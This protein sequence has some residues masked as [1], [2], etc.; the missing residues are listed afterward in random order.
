MEIILSEENLSHSVVIT[1]SVKGNS[2]G[3]KASF[4]FLFSNKK[5]DK[6]DN[7]LS[8]ARPKSSPVTEVCS[9]FRMLQTKFRLYM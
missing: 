4:V 8:L 6:D 7:F 1:N 9:T 3:E 5:I 2:N